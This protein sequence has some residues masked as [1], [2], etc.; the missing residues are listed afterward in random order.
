MGIQAG[1]ILQI[2][3][4]SPDGTVFFT[5]DEAYAN[6]KA[7]QFSYTGQKRTTPAW[8]PGTY[9]GSATLIRGGQAVFKQPLGITVR[10]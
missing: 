6:P 8:L 3:M 9:S 5:K 1:D 2:R 7:A 4:I 10:E